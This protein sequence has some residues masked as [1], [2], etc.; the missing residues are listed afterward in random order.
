MLRKVAAFFITTAPI[1]LVLVFSVLIFMIVLTVGAMAWQS[2][3]EKWE[4]KPPFWIELELGLR[5]E[6]FSAAS[7]K[8]QQ[9]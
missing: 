9:G 6:A 2:N 3:R 8:T 4:P 5:S 1:G 7:C